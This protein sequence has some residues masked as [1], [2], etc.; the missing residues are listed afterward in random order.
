MRSSALIF[1]TFAA[2]RP[3]ASVRLWPHLGE[4]LD[5]WWQRAR[6]CVDV[7]NDADSFRAGREPLTISQTRQAHYACFV[8]GVA[9]AEWATSRT[10]CAVIVP[11]SMGLFAAYHVAGALE[12]EEALQLMDR[13]CLLLHE[14]RPFVPCST[15]AIAGLPRV[16]V[17]ELLASATVPVWIA[18]WYDDDVFLVSGP[19][20]AVEAILKRAPARGAT[21][22]K[23]TPATAP[24]HTPELVSF[25]ESAHQYLAGVIVSPPRI[26]VISSIDGSVSRTADD[27]RREVARNACHPMN[28][29]VAVKVLASNA[30]RVDTVVEC[31]SSVSLTEMIRHHLPIDSAP[32]TIA[33]LAR[34]AVMS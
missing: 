19:Q 2:R 29:R 5:Y 12:F 33:A 28:W 20:H 31:G 1:P 13:L 16:A 14:Q 26:P 10:S 24:Y 32:V 30:F 9:A 22:T 15:G 25:E 6:T 11:H 18:D 8:E 17:D 4:R 27:V 21:Y 23:S 34:E 7:E 3:D